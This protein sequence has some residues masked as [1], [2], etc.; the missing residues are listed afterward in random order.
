MMTHTQRGPLEWKSTT[1]WRNQPLEARLHHAKIPPRWKDRQ[2]K[3]PTGVQTW[4]DDYSSGKNLYLHGKHSVGKS[5]IASALLV[6]MLSELG[7]SGRFTTTH[8]YLE[9]IKDS[10]EHDGLLSDMYSM[11]HLIQYI[12]GVFDVVVLDGFGEE[13]SSEFN[14]Y[15]VTTLLKRRYEDMRSIIITSTL[16]PSQA[17][18]VYGQSI[19]SFI[20]DSDL[21]VV[22]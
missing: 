8:K 2:I 7:L 17:L 9:M 13:R 15:E 18:G 3:L 10:F 16:S 14:I 6:K 19:S 21:V 12:Q 4:L 22:S 11:P 1:W 5:H 20:L